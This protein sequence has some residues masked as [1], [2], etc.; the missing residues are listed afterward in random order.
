M[1][2]LWFP[3]SSLNTSLN[4]VFLK[5]WSSH[6]WPSPESAAH[7]TTATQGH[8]TLSLW[9][10]PRRPDEWIHDCGTF[11]DVFLFVVFVLFDGRYL[12]SSLLCF[13]LIN[14]SKDKS[15]MFISV[16][17]SLELGK[18]HPFFSSFSSFFL[19]FLSFF[20]SLTRFGSVDDS[21]PSAIPARVQGAAC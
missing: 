2:V 19:F 15:I 17:L 14:E 7:T 12:H 1:F 4:R 18:F 10:L 21:F 8:L 3:A 16:A 13:C 9:P 5:I 6:P 11:P 20:S